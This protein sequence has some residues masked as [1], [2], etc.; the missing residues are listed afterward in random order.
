MELAKP[1]DLHHGTP[2][3]GGKAQSPSILSHVH[4]PKLTLPRTVMGQ[5]FS[6]PV[7]Q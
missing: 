4:L 6:L 5:G 7:D 3:A 1:S 2:R